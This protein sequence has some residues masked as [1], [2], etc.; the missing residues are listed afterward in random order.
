MCD[1]TGRRDGNRRNKCDGGVSETE[2]AL[3]YHFKLA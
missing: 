3:F 1:H 2:R